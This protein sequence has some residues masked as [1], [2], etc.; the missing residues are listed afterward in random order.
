MAARNCKT[1]GFGSTC[2]G[3]NNSNNVAAKNMWSVYDGF[4]AARFFEKLLVFVGKLL[5]TD[6][7]RVQIWMVHQL[8]HLQ[9]MPRR[10]RF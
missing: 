5:H 8:G 3:I 2:Q 6:V 7:H 10:T 1:A 4:Y 9:S